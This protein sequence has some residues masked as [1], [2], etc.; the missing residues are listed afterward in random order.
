MKYMSVALKNVP[1]VQPS[2]PDG[3]VKVQI[4]S[5][6]GLPT[7][8]GETGVPEYFYQEAVPIAK[9]QADPNIGEPQTTGTPQNGTMTPPLL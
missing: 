2:P 9:T 3:V 5:L 7:G 8:E 6:T 4:N 1:Q